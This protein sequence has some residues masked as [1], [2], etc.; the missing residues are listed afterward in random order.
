MK[1][2]A[3]DC[4][5]S[6]LSIALSLDDKIFKKNILQSNC[7]SE[8]MIDAVNSIILEAGINFKDLDFIIVNRGP[9]S[10]TSIRVALTFAQMAKI[11][12][13][14]P[15]I[16]CN[17]LEI[18]NYYCLAN[19]AV[20]SKILNFTNFSKKFIIKIILK[21]SGGEFFCQKFIIDKIANSNKSD[22]END[23]NFIVAKADPVVID[24][25][26]YSYFI[27]DEKELKTIIYAINDFSKILT[28]DDIAVENRL[29]L[30][31]DNNPC[32]SETIINFVKNKLK[33]QEINQNIADK[34]NFL[35]EAAI[36][37]PLYL[38]SV[39]ISKPAT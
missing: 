16:S 33:R 5:N 37:E 29:L 18:L 21:A 28:I 17:Y 1:I 20:G 38:R 39:R 24:N 23:Y 22:Y 10:F 8:L 11:S 35:E 27:Y 12:L 13:S 25:A 36:L 9:G 4:C 15:V 30:T 32:D 26:S 34:E 3:I 31:F 2:L 6:W 19:P 7:Q 14:I